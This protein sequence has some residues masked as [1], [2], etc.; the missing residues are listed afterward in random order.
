MEMMNNASKYF[1]IIVQAK[2]DFRSVI[3]HHVEK[4][5]KRTKQAIKT[6]QVQAN[7]KLVSSIHP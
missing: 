2:I 4:L 5:N 6:T 7:G 1:F 3:E